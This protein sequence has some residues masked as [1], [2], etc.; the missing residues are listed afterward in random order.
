MQKQLV[1]WNWPQGPPLSNE[2]EWL[3]SAQNPVCPLNDS[4]FSESVLVTLR[5]VACDAFGQRNHECPL[6]ICLVGSSEAARQ[7]A[8]GFA[9]TL[10]LPFVGCRSSRIQST[11]DILVRIAQVAETTRFP[12][13]Q[14][15]GTLEL[16]PVIELDHPDRFGGRSFFII[17]PMVVFVRQVELLNNDVLH[18]LRTACDPV[19]PILFTGEWIADTRFVSWFL[20]CEHDDDLPDEFDHLPV[21]GRTTL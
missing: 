3:V 8:C 16:V 10:G 19:E 14:G 20:H 21:L 9:N 17:P 7:L 5:R 12:T 1:F 15:H 6:A 11:N 2:R 18:R 4:G 13:P